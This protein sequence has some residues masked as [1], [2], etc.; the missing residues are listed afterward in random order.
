MWFGT[1]SDPEPKIDK[2]R[3]DVRLKKK[4]ADGDL[5]PSKRVRGLAAQGYEMGEVIGEGQFSKVLVAYC[6][7]MR[8]KVAVKVISKRKSPKEYLRD[9]APRE[10]SILQH[11]NHT[12]MIDIYRALEDQR[13]V[14]L[15]MEYA[16][17]GDLHDYINTKGHLDEAESRALFR[18][19]IEAVAYL[20]RARV[21]HRDIRPENCLLA[22]G[23]QLKLADFG[24]A[25]WNRNKEILSTY[26]G[27]YGYAAPEV[28]E[29]DPY[30]GEK[31]D[32]WSMG[33][34]LFSMLNGREPFPDSGDI[35]IL[36]NSMAQKMRFHQKTSKEARVFVRRMMSL[37]PDARPTAVELR[38]DTWIEKPCQIT[39]TYSES[40]VT[41][42][43]LMRDDFD[44]N[45]EHGLS[46]GQHNFEV[47]PKAV[48]KLL[49]SVAL[50]SID[51]DETLVRVRRGVAR[52]NSNAIGISG[53]AARRVS[54]ALTSN[55]DVSKLP[56]KG[57]TTG[58]TLGR[59]MSSM[60]RR[61][62]S[63]LRSGSQVQLPAQ[64]II[65][66][67]IKQHQEEV[68][69]DIKRVHC[70]TGALFAAAVGKARRQT[71]AANRFEMQYVQVLHDQIAEETGYVIGQTRGKMERLRHKLERM[72]GGDETPS[73]AGC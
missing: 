20:H 41:S 50:N 8:R 30:D 14:Y 63:I 36:L 44:L 22:E 59:R 66:T 19:L 5:L 21:V 45:Q 72:A 23:N 67:M 53:P 61:S 64:E 25:R 16:P 51:D 71:I 52:I 13:N 40:S 69:R 33:A 54:V 46:L 27:C 58:K 35:G 9:F 6:P 42:S 37:D 34:T 70:T 39:D 12:Y 29:G 18:Q 24:F 56:V 43:V 38:S 10:V 17:N 48:T 65:D 55:V 7:K 68:E 15:V 3:D 73:E 49:K 1:K 47:P 60:L 11:L 31:S 32:V 2:I 4:R 28:V 26:C 57:S 62:S